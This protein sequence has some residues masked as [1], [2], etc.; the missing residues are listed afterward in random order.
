M[1]MLILDSLSLVL[2]PVL[3][4]AWDASPLRRRLGSGALS[5]DQVNRLKVIVGL[6]AAPIAIAILHGMMTLLR[7]RRET[8]SYGLAK[9]A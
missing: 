3:K 5:G 7:A 8:C 6:W 9:C 4:K 2:A 1:G